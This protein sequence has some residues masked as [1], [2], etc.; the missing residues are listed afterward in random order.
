MITSER[1]LEQSVPISTRKSG[2]LPPLSASSATMHH[3]FHEDHGRMP[4]LTVQTSSPAKSASRQQSPGHGPYSR[5]SSPVH[6]TYSPIT[7]VL[8]AARLAPTASSNI[9]PSSSSPP[10]QAF[11]GNAATYYTHSAAPQTFI[12]QPPPQPITLE[13]NPDAIALRSAISILQLQRHH[14]QTDIRT[15]QSIKERAVDDPQGFA[16]ALRDRTINTKPDSLFTPRMDEEDSEDEVKSESQGM[17]RTQTGP[18]R[19]WPSIPTPQTIVRCP[20]INWAQYA[21]VGES[22]DKLHAEQ[23]ER[24]ITGFPQRIGRDGFLVHYEGSDRRA[25]P[26]VIASPYAPGKDKLDRLATRK[27]GKR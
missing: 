22:L 3:V 6:P 12:S 18:G 10:G 15:L 19:S 27:G 16:A 23:Q 5:S 14:A 8:A 17:N 26:A 9:P 11:H 2:N 24:P 25:E 21:V 1:Q 7:P 13:E 4:A 20:P